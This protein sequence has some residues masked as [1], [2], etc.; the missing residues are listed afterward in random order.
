M[1]QSWWVILAS[2][3]PPPTEAKLALLLFNTAARAI[4]EKAKAGPPGPEL[5][6]APVPSRA[7]PESPSPSGPV[8]GPCLSPHSP[9]P[10]TLASWLFPKP[11]RHAPT[12]RVCTCGPLC[13]E[14][15]SCVS[16]CLIRHLSL[17][18]DTHSTSHFPAVVSLS[19]M[20]PS[21]SPS[22]TP[23]SCWSPV[24]TSRRS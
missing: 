12:L 2:H 9:A 19:G 6:D 3:A 1:E 17:R 16:T 5:C 18:I 10:T 14:C 8:P 4:L 11:P 13:P 22:I 7:E 24:F 21:N 15:G 23:V 20:C